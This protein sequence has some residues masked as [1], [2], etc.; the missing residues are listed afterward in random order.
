MTIRDTVV[1]VGDLR[2]PVREAGPSC[3][4]PVVLLHG[5]PDCFHSFDAQLEALAA[6]GYHA[7][8]P[9]L[10]GYA[11]SAIPDDGDYFLETIVGDVVGLMDTLDIERAHLVGHDWG[12]AIAWLAVAMHPDRFVT[13]T[14]IAIPPLGGMLKA[15]RRYPGQARNSW[16]MAFFQLRGIADRAV[17]R[18]D[19]AFIER[20]WRDWSPGW[21]WPAETMSR[22]KQTFR[23]PGVRTAALGYYRHLFRWFAA[24]NKRT[25][26]RIAHPVAMPAL[27]LHGQTDGCMDARLPAAAI[28]AARFDAGVRLAI[29]PG[30]GHFLH[31]EQPERTSTLLLDFFAGHPL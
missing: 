24:P 7:L 31:Q 9:A 14:S 16:Y 27:V 21:V 28:Q 15:V 25:R 2:F 10:R 11:A 8:A 17:A 6:A 1:T 20:L 3:G 19:Y 12:A 30:A 4:V 29:V 13:V 26:A 23:Q 5:F 22:V 18:D